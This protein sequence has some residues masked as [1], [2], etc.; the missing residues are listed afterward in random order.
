MAHI[1]E[2]PAFPGPDHDLYIILTVVNNREYVF[3]RLD[4]SLISSVAA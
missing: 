2:F 1:R 4:S 3:H